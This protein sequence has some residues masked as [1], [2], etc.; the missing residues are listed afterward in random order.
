M[1]TVIGMLVLMGG[2]AVARWRLGLYVLIFVGFFQD[3]V[4]KLD[5]DQNVV[6]TAIV[7]AF[8]T[9]VV[10]GMYM[11]GDN[12]KA[13][14]L[15]AI[16][17]TLAIPIYLFSFLIVL[18][19]GRG[20]MQAGTPIILGIG[21]LAYFAPI[22]SVLIGYRY[23]AL[24]GNVLGLLR[25]YT[26]VGLIFSVGVYL[27]AMG[28]EWKILGSVGTGI[29]IYTYKV[30]RLV[31][32]FLRAS[33]T[34]AWHGAMV[35]M[36]AM[37]LV[38]VERVLLYKFAWIMTAAMAF[39]AV[40]LTGRRKALVE[41]GVFVAFST[42][43]MIIGRRRFARA[44][45]GAVLGLGMMVVAVLLYLPFGDIFGDFDAILQRLTNFTRSPLERVWDMTIGSFNNVISY[46][47]ILGAGAGLGSQGAQYFGG[48]RTGASAESGFGKVLA[49]IGVI[50]LV[51]FFWVLYRIGRYGRAILITLRGVHGYEQLSVGIAAILLANI[52]N[53]MAAHQ[54]YGD[55]FVI[56]ILGLLLGIF[57][58][59]PQLAYR[60]VDL[61]VSKRL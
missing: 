5:P 59:L 25:F 15:L 33:E 1:A 32:G 6:Y 61:T 29:Y 58:S 56:I 39:G 28:T 17:P 16:Y 7:V 14:R 50:G 38:T 52:V 60:G 40:F 12:K 34:A 3:I 30:V 42:I 47:S 54:A 31:S 49:E 55:P 10:L 18:Q 41:I 36:I 51:V 46:N 2:T 43:L 57:L 19:A 27:E 13:G 4:R 21:L 8:A 45:I 23:V 11:S 44:Y 24:T 26:V 37:V 20:Y 9:F 53:F 48:I 22:V 35:T